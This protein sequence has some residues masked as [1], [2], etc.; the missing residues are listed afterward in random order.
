MRIGAHPLK[1]AF[2][3]FG[4]NALMTTVLASVTCCQFTTTTT[5]TV[6]EV[7]RACYLVFRVIC[8]RSSW[9]YK[10]ILSTLLYSLA[11]GA[12]T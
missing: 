3:T 4:P 11:V 12:V 6:K 9:T 2:V 1:F 7:K 5:T 10:R 8:F